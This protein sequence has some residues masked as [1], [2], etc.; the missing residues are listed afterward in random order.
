[1][2]WIRR[3]LAVIVVFLVAVIGLVFLLP[4]E[5]IGELASAQLEKSTGRSLTLSGEFRPSFY[6]I[7]GVKTGP[8]T[9]SNASWASEPYMITAEGASVGVGLSALFGGDLEIQ[10]LILDTPVIHLERNQNGE[11]NWVLLDQGE[12]Q[13]QPSGS[14]SGEGSS[15]SVR[16][17]ALEKGKIS[18]GK[19]TLKDASGAQSFVLEHIN[20]DFALA[21]NGGARIDGSARLNDHPIDLDLS[22]ENVNQLLEG[23]ITSLTSTLKLSG[24]TAAFQGEMRT[25]TANAPPLVNIQYDFDLPDPEKLTELSGQALPETLKGL[26]AFNSQGTL[27]VSEA[28][29]SLIGETAAVLNEIPVVAQ[30]DINSVDDWLNTLRMELAL[31]VEAENAFTFAWKGLL[32]GKTGNADGTVDFDANNLPRTLKLVNQSAGFPKGTGQSASLKGKLRVR[33]GKNT[34]SDAAFR[35][36]QNTYHGQAELTFEDRP[37]IAANLTAGALDLKAYTADENG[38]T[39]SGSGGGSG[40]SSGGSG[41]GWSKEPIRIS[42][43]DAVDADV[44]LRAKSVDLGVSQLGRTD[45]TMRLREGTLYMALNQVNAFQGVITGNVSFRGGAGVAFNSD[46][47]AKSVQLEPLLGRLL[48]I[49]R[50]TGTGN[51]TLKMRG[52]GGSLYDIMHSLSGNGTVRVDEGSFKGIDLAAMMRNL[53]S[54]FGGFQ[55]ATEFSVL[56]GTFTMKDGVLQNVDLNLVTP[57]FK[58]A[59]QGRVNVGDQTMNYRVTPTALPEDAKFSVPILISGP[60]SNLRFAPDLKGLVNLFAQK[61]LNL[62]KD[63]LKSKAEEKLRDKLKLNTENSVQSQEEGQSTETAVKKKI[64]EELGGNVG[65]ILKNIFD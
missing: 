52:T 57:L 13:T 46:I 32:N 18:N 40:G 23:K 19:I 50:L 20:T 51:T 47:T 14:S 26:S 1:M 60:W 8:L 4:A 7:L 34:I 17:I 25:A 53:K 3:I 10:Q 9:I 44:H 62:K 42:G 58:A 11:A 64:E 30:F 27:M 29:L 39:T 2:R 45:V 48:N 12:P 5:K 31:N 21:S 38:G 6:P 35:L 24:I 33:D 22:V 15:G 65:N 56:T 43:L 59:G 41:S 36:D 61:E 28:G 37:Y 49:H 54:A 16:T 55:G 63:E